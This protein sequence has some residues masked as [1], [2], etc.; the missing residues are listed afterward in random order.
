MYIATLI[1]PGFA[2]LV[3]AR[4]SQSTQ[5]FAPRPVVL[6]QTPVLTLSANGLAIDGAGSHSMDVG[7]R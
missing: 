3:A 4:P 6:P 7:S 2:H 5:G 1:H